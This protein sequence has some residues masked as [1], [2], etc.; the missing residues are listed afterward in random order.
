MER[1]EA[2]GWWWWCGEHPGEEEQ[3]EEETQEAVEGEEGQEGQEENMDMEVE[4]EEV[5]A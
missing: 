3:E 1:L 4:E 5:R 2:R